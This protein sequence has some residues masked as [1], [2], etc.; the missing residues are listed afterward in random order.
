M[1]AAVKSI[2]VNYGLL[3]LTGAVGYFFAGQLGV[4]LGVTFGI[5]VQTSWRRFRNR[6]VYHE[7]Y[8]RVKSHYLET[9][10]STEM[11]PRP[12]VALVPALLAFAIL[13]PCY[14]IVISLVH[15]SNTAVDWMKSIHPAVDLLVPFI[16][17]LRNMPLDLV[18]TG[19]ADWAPVVQHVLFV[20]W[21]FSAPLAAWTML[22]VFVLHRHAW[23][24][25]VF[26]NSRSEII[27]KFLLPGAALIA[28]LMLFLFVGWWPTPSGQ[29]SLGGLGMFQSPLLAF[30]FVGTMLF[31]LSLV[32]AGNALLQ[33][34]FF[35]DYDAGNQPFDAAAREMFELTLRRNETDPMKDE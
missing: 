13:F 26:L 17:A 9:A 35:G 28:V 22:D 31:F 32:M 1:G 12:S 14:A 21:A 10:L 27:K 33:R 29:G 24:R 23:N 30:L 18:N 8:E 2:V 25:A 34:S 15:D 11:P 4:A 6:L 7:E 20:G 5:V 16:P 19:H 3:L